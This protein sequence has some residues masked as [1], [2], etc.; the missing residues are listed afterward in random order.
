MSLLFQFIHYQSIYSSP[1]SSPIVSL[2]HVQE[3]MQAYKE[4][5]K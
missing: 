1:V 3:K 4:H 5:I 2:M